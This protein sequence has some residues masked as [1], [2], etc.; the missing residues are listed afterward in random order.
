MSRK[1][2]HPARSFLIELLVYAGLVIVYVFFVITLLGGWLNKLYE[3]HKI[4]YAVVA[5]LLIIGQGVM[6][7]MV[8]TL[9]L[10]LVRSR[11]E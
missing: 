5:L 3:Y 7:E 9:L 8:T 4:H 1:D 10:K 2:K 11:T 6:L